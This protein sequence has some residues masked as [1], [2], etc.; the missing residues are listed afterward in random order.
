MIRT[1]L[2]LLALGTALAAAPASAATQITSVAAD[3][4]N[5]L[6]VPGS[7][8]NM[9]FDLDAGTAAEAASKGLTATFNGALASRTTVSPT[10]VTPYGVFAFAP[11]PN[12]GN[13]YFAIGGID[14]F[15]LQ[16]SL[17]LL[18]TQAFSSISLFVGSLDTYNTVELLDAA[19]TAIGTYSGTAMSGGAIPLGAMTPSNN[20]RVTFT[21][22]DGTVFYGAKFYNQG[23]N[24]AFEFDNVSFTAAVPEP[25]TWAMMI[26]GFGMV[27][28]AARNRRRSTAMQTA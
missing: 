4:S 24:S 2:S 15:G 22:T 26:L 28:F 25:A 20:R 6:A 16:S 10:G 7:T 11:N 8:I 12:D 21:G 18:G 17:Q 5:H 3:G 23:N 27:G 9:T 1:A 13:G 14:S 19:G